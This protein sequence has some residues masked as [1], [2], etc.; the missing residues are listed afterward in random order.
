MPYLL[1]FHAKHFWNP[2]SILINPG[3]VLCLGSDILLKMASAYCVVIIV[4]YSLENPTQML[5]YISRCLFG[6]IMPMQ[7][8]R[9]DGVHGFP[10][11]HGILKKSSGTHGFWTVC[12]ANTMKKY[13]G[14]SISRKKGKKRNIFTVFNFEIILIPLPFEE[15]FFGNPW[16]WNPNAATAMVIR[17]PTLIIFL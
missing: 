4:N 17:V 5:I 16:I 2:W 9:L 8:L 14:A 10:R 7:W 13:L 1:G 3:Q 6:K 11:T 15:K 12:H